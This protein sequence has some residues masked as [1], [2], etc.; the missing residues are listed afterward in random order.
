LKKIFFISIVVLAAAIIVILAGRHSPFGK[1]NSSFA[2]EPKKEITRIVFSQ[3]GE[4]LTLENNGEKWL[5][6]G[7]LETRKSSISNILRVLKELNIK[8]PVSPEHFDTAIIKNKISPVRVRTYENRRL[9]KDFFVYKT[10]SN[11]YGNIMK[12]GR[13]AKPFIVYVPGHDG[14]IGSVFT[15]NELYWQPYTIFNLLPSE[16]TT[17]V[18]ENL[19]DQTKSFS[20]TKS[21]SGYLL[22]DGEKTLSGY[23]TDLIKRYLTYFTYIPFESWAIGMDNAIMR[24]FPDDPPLYRIQVRSKNSDIVLSLWERKNPDGTKDSDRMY[25]RTDANDAIFIVRYF[26]I[27]PILK[28]RD[29]FFNQ[30]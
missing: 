17:I 15:M 8:S 21:E 7:R 30:E 2:S 19:A 20:I 6:D 3:E 14:D 18:F 22:T 23:D 28:E 10:R 27:D 4:E 5:L 13:K 26:D 29:Y 16:I 9:L 25:G 1:R 24:T 12:A 11:I